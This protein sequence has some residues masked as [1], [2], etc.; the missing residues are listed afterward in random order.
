M[1]TLLPLLA[2]LAAAPFSFF[3]LRRLLG[4]DCLP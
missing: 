1:E 3:L 4:K 2:A